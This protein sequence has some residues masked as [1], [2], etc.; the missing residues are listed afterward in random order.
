M[1]RVSTTRRVL[2]T[3]KAHCLLSIDAIKKH[4]KTYEDSEDEEDDKS[5]G[6]AAAMQALKLFNKGETK[7]SSS[8]QSAFL[9]LAM[10]EASKVSYHLP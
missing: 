3:F 2:Y 6:T 10:A 4:K 1:R 8:S 7:S 5:M 9:G